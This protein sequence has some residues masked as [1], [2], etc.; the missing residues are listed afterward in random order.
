[1]RKLYILKVVV[2][3]A[4]VCICVLVIQATSVCVGKMDIVWRKTF[5]ERGRIQTGQLRALVNHGNSS[6]SCTYIYLLFFF[7]S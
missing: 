4:V 6:C 1:M 5:G 7:P 2:V 3:V